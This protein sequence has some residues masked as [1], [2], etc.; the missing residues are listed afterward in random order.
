MAPNHYLNQCWNILNW[1]LR[2][3]LQWNDN[4]NT[5]IFIEKKI[6]LNSLLPIWC[7]AIIW[8]NA[9]LLWITPQVTN[10]KQILFEFLKFSLK[11][12]HLKMLPAKWHPFCSSFI[13][14]TTK[15][16]YQ[17]KCKRKALLL[18]WLIT[19]EIYRYG[20]SFCDIPP[21]WNVTGSWNLSSSITRVRIILCMCQ[22]NDRWHYSVMSSRIGC[23]YTEWSLQGIPILNVWYYSYW[24]SGQA[25]G[26]GI[27]SHIYLV[28]PASFRPHT[29]IMVLP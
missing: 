15:W 28:W 25:R 11:T 19:F 24:W 26:Q 10:F 2:N 23:V 1:T 8:T 18:M 29:I 17:K 7:R 9:N 6:H 4:R 3:K 22:A 12:M 5:N 27:N 20:I 13:M 21:H 14:L 16:L